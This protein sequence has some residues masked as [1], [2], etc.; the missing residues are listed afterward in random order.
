MLRRQ[1]GLV[2]V[3]HP[4]VVAVFALLLA[5]LAFRA[6]EPL[7]D[8]LPE[9]RFLLFQ[10]HRIQQF[11]GIDDAVGIVV[12]AQ[13][14]DRDQ[15]P[16][17]DVP[18]LLR[19]PVLVPVDGGVLR[20]S[21]LADEHVVRLVAVADRR[22]G[23][24]VRL[25]DDALRVLG[26]RLRVGDLGHLVGRVFG[27]FA[28]LAVGRL[29]QF[30]RV[31]GALEL[32]RGGLPHGGEVAFDP[33]ACLE[34]EDDAAILLVLRS[35]LSLFGCGG[36]RHADRCEQHDELGDAFHRSM[37]LGVVRQGK[38]AG[39]QLDRFV[40]RGVRPADP[41]GRDRVVGDEIGDAAAEG[42]AC[43]A[44]QPPGRAEVAGGELLEVEL[45]GRGTEDAA[46]DEGGRA[47]VGEDRVALAGVDERPEE[48]RREVE[49]APAGA[50]RKE[51]VAFGGIAGMP[52]HHRVDSVRMVGRP[53][54]R[55]AEGVAE[56]AQRP[57]LAGNLDAVAVREVDRLACFQVET[58]FDERRGSERR[59]PEQEQER[60]QDLFH[61][62]GD[63]PSIGGDPSGSVRRM[64][65]MQR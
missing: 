12:E 6:L 64:F 25:P 51:G 47:A 29:G 60:K 59:A 55:F 23:Y 36:Q 41:L 15:D 61:G 10:Q 14:K 50:R 20:R 43:R 39:E 38:V 53:L 45:D 9:A 2:A 52:Q 19:R 57:V 31:V 17:A 49:T 7:L 62:G 63:G 3:E 44:V 32:E 1:I 26:R 21:I 56:G 30:E 4:G 35:L 40:A 11:V 46:A 33:F 8:V 24:G 13:A 22:T 16:A 5:L 28:P 34:G 37:R 18:G 54:F 42:V 58:A 65:L 48:G 27:R